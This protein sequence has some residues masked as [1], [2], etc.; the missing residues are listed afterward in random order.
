MMCM[1]GFHLRTDKQAM[2]GLR[3]GFEQARKQVS[4]FDSG[5]WEQ[6][7]ITVLRN[8]DRTLAQQAKDNSELIKRLIEIMER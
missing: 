6:V 1:C 5:E 3:K 4:R 2:E 8:L 7:D